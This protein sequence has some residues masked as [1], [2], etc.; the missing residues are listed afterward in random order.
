M[1]KTNNEGADAAQQ[2]DIFNI[3]KV[4]V[5][6]GNAFVRLPAKNLRKILILLKRPSY[7]KTHNFRLG[8]LVRG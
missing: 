3:N 7:G 5:K 1:K 6:L 4:E 8:P 2:L